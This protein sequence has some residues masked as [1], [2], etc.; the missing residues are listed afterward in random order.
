M[1][2]RGIQFMKSLF[3]GVL[4]VLTY[5]MA[6]NNEPSVLSA[7]N[8]IFHEAGHFIFIFFGETLQI[9]GG[10]LMQL[11]VPLMCFVAFL[12]Q[13]D[14]YACAI[15]LWWCGDNLVNISIYIADSNALVLSLLG[16]GAHDWNM[17]LAKWNL[18]VHAESIGTA[19]GHVGTFIMVT[20][21]I[22]AI[23]LIHLQKKYERLS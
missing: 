22:W 4:A 20:S 15:M 8:L 7:I 19:T 11:I 5:C 16:N 6:S 9:L 14:F 3:L 13:R 12:R 17:L 10:S 23:S 21:I 1:P 2:I 18:L